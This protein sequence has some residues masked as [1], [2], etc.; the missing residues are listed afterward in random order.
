MANSVSWFE[1]IGTDG[2]KLRDFYG[3]LF[4]W[5]FHE[6]EGIDYGMID[7]GPGGIGGGI[8]SGTGTGQSYVTV[9]V[10]VADIN[11]S[12]KQAEQLGGKTLVPRTVIPNQV[13][14]AL[15]SDPE[16]HLV[17]LTEGV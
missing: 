5:H 2:P 14:F 10:Q 13:T 16:G 11:A 12:L 8:G 6:A 4:G 1:I 7:A 15:F 9:Y 17:G 3:R